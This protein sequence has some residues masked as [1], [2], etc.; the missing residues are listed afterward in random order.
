LVYARPDTVV[1]G[2]RERFRKFWARLS[3]VNRRRGAAG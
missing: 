1:R 3:R 2:Q